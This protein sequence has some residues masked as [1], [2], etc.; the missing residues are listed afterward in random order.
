MEGELAPAVTV[1]TINWTVVAAV[2]GDG[3]IGAR[4]ELE[5]PVATNWLEEENTLSATVVAST[6]R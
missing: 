3:G 6:D 4:N 2:E 5:G 1:S